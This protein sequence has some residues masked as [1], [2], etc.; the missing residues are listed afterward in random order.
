M[1]QL[2]QDA[3]AAGSQLAQAKADVEGSVAEADKFYR[4]AQDAVALLTKTSNRE[5]RERDRAWASKESSRLMQA[6][7][8]LNNLQEGEDSAYT[9]DS[10][11]SEV[12][13]SIKTTKK[14]LADALARKEDIDTTLSTVDK[15]RQQKKTEVEADMAPADISIEKA[16]IEASR[17][18]L[19]AAKEQLAMRQQKIQE[20]KHAAA[21]AAPKELKESPKRTVALK[22]KGMFEGSAEDTS[23]QI[24]YAKQQLEAKSRVEHNIQAGIQEEIKRQKAM[25]AKH[26]AS[27]VEMPP[28]PPSAGDEEY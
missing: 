26:T 6:Q 4:M 14:R 10:T 12:A 3:D 5:Y 1:D 16:E 28:L 13:E 9:Q 20:H 15:L 27:L 23:K 17:Q 25:Q 21:K 7:E 2:L 11:M 24:A 18:K 19:K 8:T 22:T